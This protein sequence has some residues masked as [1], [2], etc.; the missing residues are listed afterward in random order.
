MRRKRVVDHDGAVVVRSVGP[1]DV[2]ALWACLYHAAHMADRPDEVLLDPRSHSDLRRY[3]EGWGREGDVGVMAVDG[4]GRLLGAAWLRCLTAADGH[5]PEYVDERTPEL[6]VAV[7]PGNRG[8]GLGTRLLEAL[9]RQ[10]TGRFPAIVLTVRDQNPASRL[11]ERLGFVAVGEI[12]NRVGS[13]S[14][15]MVLTLPWPAL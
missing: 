6:A 11:Y 5:R 9:V 13:P 14:T 1:E 3:V 7:L 8:E 4:R 12:T 15:K 2:D 10:A